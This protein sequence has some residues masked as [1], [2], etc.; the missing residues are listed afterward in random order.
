MAADVIEGAELAVV[1]A[2]D[3]ERFLVYING[4]ELAGFLDLVQMADDLPVGGE[5]GVALELGDA[6]VEIPGSGDGEGFL[7]RIGGI[8]E[9][10]DFADGGVG[11]KR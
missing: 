8:V 6:S 5:D 4:E 9:V 7:E 3:D 11:H 10:E 2:D 1:A